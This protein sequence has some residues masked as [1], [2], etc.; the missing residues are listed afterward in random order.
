MFVSKWGLLFT[1]FLTL[2][3]CKH[4]VK[5]YGDLDGFP[6]HLSEWNLFTGR[7][8]ELHPNEGVVAY[9]LNTPLFSNY[10]AKHRFVWMPKGTSAAYQDRELFEFPVGTVLAKTFG[11]DRLLETRVLV[12]T[13]SGWT[14]L[15]Y[16]WNAEQ[17]DAKLE[18][19]PAP[20]RVTYQG[21]TFDYAI[22]GANQC[23]SCHSRSKVATPLGVKARNLNRDGQLEHWAQ[24]GYLRGAPRANEIPKAAV[25]NDGATGT[26][27][28]RAQAY[29]DVNCAHCHESGF[30]SGNLLVGMESLDPKVMMPSLGRSVVHREGVALIHEWL[31]SRKAP[32]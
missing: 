27:D 26:L 3:A 6:D 31:Q 20:V 2:A 32:L 11:Y 29:L 17:T 30:R 28:A 12:R 16:V 4:P 24:I 15:P 8:S 10:A 13:A 21:Q 5:T 23:A 22:P 1:G 9:E 7:L 14:A 18:M 25:W 19:T